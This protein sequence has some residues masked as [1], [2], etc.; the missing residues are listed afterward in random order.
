[1]PGE[2]IVPAAHVTVVVLQTTWQVI[3]V[4]L[5]HFTM[6]DTQWLPAGQSVSTVQS[7]KTGPA[8]NGVAH[9]EETLPG[10]V[11]Q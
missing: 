9:A 6:L 4:W 3:E 8:Q 11:V 10:S 2:Q 1:V 5:Q 7:W